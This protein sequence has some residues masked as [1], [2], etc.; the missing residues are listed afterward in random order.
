MTSNSIL[1]L[2][3]SI[4]CIAIASSAM[5]YYLYFLPHQSSIESEIKAR[6]EVLRNQAECQNAGKDYVAS[7][8]KTSLS[9][10]TISWSHE[11][12]YYNAGSNKCFVTGT[13]DV[14]LN[15]QFLHESYPIVNVYTNEL[16]Y[17]WSTKINDDGSVTDLHGSEGEYKRKLNE[18]LPAN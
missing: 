14:V 17:E 13:K 6:S 18:L 4:S 15:K 8:S 1:K 10:L 2:S 3:I 16:I 9:V 5:Y 11:K 7:D 12:Y